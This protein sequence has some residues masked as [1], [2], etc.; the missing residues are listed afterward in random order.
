MQI[1]SSATYRSLNPASRNQRI[2]YDYRCFHWYFGVYQSNV[3]SHR[4]R[5]FG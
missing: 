4:Q 3:S 5:Q 2:T 1:G